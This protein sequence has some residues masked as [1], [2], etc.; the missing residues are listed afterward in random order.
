[1]GTREI[2]IRAILSCKNLSE[3]TQV[4]S[5]RVREHKKVG[6]RWSKVLFYFQEKTCVLLRKRVI[7]YLDL[8][9][10]GKEIKIMSVLQ[11]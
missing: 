10:C 9:N 6:N 1:M 3:C 11:I 2:Q 4:Y 7:T 5:L 8:I